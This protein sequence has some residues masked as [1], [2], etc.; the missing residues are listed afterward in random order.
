MEMLL[1]MPISITIFSSVG[2]PSDGLSSTY[3]TM[4]APCRFFRSGSLFHSSTCSTIFL[5]LSLNSSNA[6]LITPS[7]VHAGSSC[8]PMYSSSDE[9]VDKRSKMARTMALWYW[10]GNV[11]SSTFSGASTKSRMSSPPISV[12]MFLRA[13]VGRLG[14]YPAMGYCPKLTAA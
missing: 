8:V 7:F 6:W 13:M 11:S 12:G 2:S 3:G 5:V 9:C 10:D 1:G 4:P 14:M